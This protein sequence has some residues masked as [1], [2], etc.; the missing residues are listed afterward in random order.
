[1]NR[2][3]K[4][5]HYM[6][7]ETIRPVIIFYAVMVLINIAGVTMNLVMTNWNFEFNGM[8]LATAI[9]LFVAGLNAFK[10][11]YLFMQANGVTRR[12]FYLGGLMTI[13]A[14]AVALTVFDTALYGLLQLI[15]QPEQMVAIQLYP[16]AA[17]AGLQLWTLAF[18]L[19]SIAFGWFLTMLYYRMSKGWKIAVSLSPAVFFTVLPI[20]SSATGGTLLSR[21]AEAFM[22]VMG[23][24]ANPNVWLGMLTLL[25]VSSVCVVL[26]YLLVR[27]AQIKEQDR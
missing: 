20:I 21:L 22:A 16:N 6:I 12:Q 9:F 14:V 26:S 1:M 17:Y 11:G 18:N 8:R 19:L 7:H 10:P 13:G 27:R 5:F 24:G 23:L 3:A 25:L 15:L 4:V 2:I